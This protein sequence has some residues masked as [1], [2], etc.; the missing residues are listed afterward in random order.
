VPSIN[1]RIQCKLSI[2]RARIRSN[3]RTPSARRHRLSRN[4]PDFPTA[5]TRRLIKKSPTA[6]PSNFSANSSCSRIRCIRRSQH[7]GC[8]R[9]SR[10]R[11]SRCAKSRQR[12]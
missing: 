10:I 6:S 4:T 8:I 2:R 3:I 5:N 12:A 11:R 7:A 1:G 9:S